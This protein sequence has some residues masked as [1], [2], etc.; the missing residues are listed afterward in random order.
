M[1]RYEDRDILGLPKDLYTY[2]IMI[3]R[4]DEK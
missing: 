3:L 2:S 4:G 1:Q